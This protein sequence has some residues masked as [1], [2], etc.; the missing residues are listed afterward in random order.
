MPILGYP[1]ASQKAGLLEKSREVPGLTDA[2]DQILLEVSPPN[3]Q[4][5]AV[6]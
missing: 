1:A 2:D 6:T 4:H 3:G 5:R